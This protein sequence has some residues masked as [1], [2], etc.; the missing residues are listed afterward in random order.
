MLPNTLQ[1]FNYG[2]LNYFSRPDERYTAGAFLHYEFNEHA[3]VYANTMF[4]D[5]FTVAQIAPSGDFAN[6]GSFDCAN[7]FLSASERSYFGCAGGGTAGLTN[8]N[9]LI[10][11]RDVER[12][13]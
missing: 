4:M 8:P 2:A 9:I 5:D 10:L 12:C 1:L 6:N 13:V 11:R 7:P 3:T